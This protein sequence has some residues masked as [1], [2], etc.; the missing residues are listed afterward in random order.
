[1]SD[2]PLMNLEI[3]ST[4]FHLGMTDSGCMFDRRNAL[5]LLHQFVTRGILPIISS[6]LL[7]KL[8]TPSCTPRSP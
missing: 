3:R 5:K 2:Q 8:S 1:M 6:K 7:M 4:C